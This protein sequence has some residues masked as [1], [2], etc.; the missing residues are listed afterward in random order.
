MFPLRVRRTLRS[1]NANNKWIGAQFAKSDEGGRRERMIRIRQL[2][3]SDQAV[4]WGYD[5]GS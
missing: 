2:A 3:E 1:A 4:P 5:I